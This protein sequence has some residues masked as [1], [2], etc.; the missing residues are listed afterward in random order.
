M[1]RLLLFAFFFLFLTRAFSQE[2]L[3]S[4]TVQAFS[5]PATLR[6]LPAGMGLIRNSDWQ[7]YS[8]A[9]ALSAFN[10]LP[11]V[12]ME[13]RSPGSYRLALRGSSLR[14]PF[15]VRNVRIYLGNAAFTD[16]GGNT[17]LNALPISFLGN[18]DI[19]K[20]PASSHYGAGTGGV[21]LAQGDTAR[22]ELLSLQ[23]M[24]GS[25][26]LHQ[27]D[28]SLHIKK[29]SLW[30][31]LLFQHQQSNGYRNQSAMRRDAVSWRS[32]IIQ[33]EKSSLE[34]RLLY[35]DLW[36]ET[37]GGL[38]QAQYAANPK[39]ARPAAGNFP[40]AETAKAAIRQ[41]VF[42]AALEQKWK[43]GDNAQ[44]L[45][46]AYHQYAN[47]ENP[48]IR[49]YEKRTEPSI[50]ARAVFGY[51]VPLGSNKL[52]LQAGT[53]YQQGWFQVNVYGNKNGRPDTTQTIDR[54]TPVNAF[55]FARAAYRLPAGFQVDASISWNRN[56]VRI[57]RESVDP[58]FVFHSQYQGEWAPRFSLLKKLGPITAYALLAK[59]FSPPTTAELLPSTSV[60]N[61]Q[62]QAEYGWNRELGLRGNVWRG[63]G[64]FDLN[65]FY[66][67][68]RNAIAQRR[69]ASGADYYENAGNNRQKGIELNIR[70]PL[71]ELPAL[72]VQP[73]LSYSLY[74]FRY[75]SFKQLQNDYTGHYIPGVAKQ[76][77][78]A[79]IDV[80]NAT[81]Q[82]FAITYQYSDPIWL[83][84]AN[85]AKASPYQLIGARMGSRIG[86]KW[87][88]FGG[89]DNL[90]NVTYS[91]GNDIN[92][93]GNR[94][95]N[96]A[97]GRNYYLGLRFSLPSPR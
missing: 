48:S 72:R 89:T 92:A 54:L 76:Q 34:A 95:Y 3:D 96:A 10:S 39:Q 62:L 28:A 46:S 86:R 29:G 11:G 44:L 71:L 58:H 64:W 53:E 24:A 15:G 21:L 68:L 45:V 75:T 77:L 8:P 57:E 9:S 27:V 43:L 85:S 26:G 35:S 37:P 70:Y 32:A 59:G 33:K 79:G 69:D 5:L 81:G 22:K 1:Q 97:A 73:W 88:A 66:F 83:N 74:S 42:F 50:G 49:N 2:Q 80:N 52:L 20:G 47:I 63:R 13:E 93:A 36:Y 14:S 60:I 7:R 78:N 91:L 41:R 38:T 67:S 12:R 19:I 55:V 65:L 87:Y 40:S 56:K 6:D 18:I 16:P 17:Y 61:Q 25:Y 82:T 4:V 31:Q 94:Y 23:Y 51:T 84:D 90:L 30:S